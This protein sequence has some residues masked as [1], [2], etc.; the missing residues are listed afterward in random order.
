MGSWEV[1]DP[2]GAA[3]ELVRHWKEE[4]DGKGWPIPQFPYADFLRESMASVVLVFRQDRTVLH[5]GM[6]PWDHGTWTQAGDRVIVRVDA[7]A[8]IMC[9]LGIEYRLRGDTLVQ[10]GTVLDY[11]PGA[12]AEPHASGEPEVVLRRSSRTVVAR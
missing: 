4:D 2:E 7:Y 9:P 11:Q 1:A 6:G 10:T 5:G 12:R 8:D 3:Q